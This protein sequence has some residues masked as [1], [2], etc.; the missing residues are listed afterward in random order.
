MPGVGL[1]AD[2]HTV[3]GFAME[4]SVSKQELLR[5]LTATQSV[6]ERKTTIPILSNFL[7]EADEAEGRL[8]ITA[9]DLD[10]SIKTSCSA[11]VKKPGSC[12]IPARKLY[13]YIKLLPDGDISIKLQDNHW[14]QIRSGRSNTKMVGMARANFPQVPEVPTAGLFKIS[15]PA[16]HNSAAVVEWSSDKVYLQ[17]LADGIKNGHADAVLAASIF[18]YG[19]HTVGEAKRF[20][21]DQGISV[22]L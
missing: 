20:M 15:V 7:L 6:V 5:E 22:R 11:K 3:Q 2:K 14:V 12:T 13:D 18:H 9:T 21:A 8:T 19:E 16:L 17:H 1:E 10:Q 4:I